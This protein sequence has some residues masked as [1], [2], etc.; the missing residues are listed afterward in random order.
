MLDTSESMLDPH[1]LTITIASV[2]SCMLETTP[3][4]KQLYITQKNK[5]HSSNS[6]SEVILMNIT[7]AYDDCNLHCETR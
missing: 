3:L 4:Y 2:N 6:V 5:T 7:N 1:M